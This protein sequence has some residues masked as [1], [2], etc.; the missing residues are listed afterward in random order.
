MYI[1]ECA[2]RIFGRKV[3]IKPLVCLQGEELG[4][5]GEEAGGGDIFHCIPFGVFGI[6]NHVNELFIKNYIK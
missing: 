1:Y 6:L 3:E 5:W 4:G 2:S